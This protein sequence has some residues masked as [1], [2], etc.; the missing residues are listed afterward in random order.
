MTVATLTD[1]LFGFLKG[2]LRAIRPSLPTELLPGAR[3]T[4]D[5]NLDSL[6]LVELIARIEQRYGLKI[7]DGD[8]QQFLSLDTTLQYIVKRIHR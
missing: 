4:A 8:L 5:L 2:E 7:P 6:D 1:D 3:Y